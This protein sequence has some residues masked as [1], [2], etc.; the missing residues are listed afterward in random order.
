MAVTHGR[1]LVKEKWVQKVLDANYCV[2]CM[3]TSAIF[4]AVLNKNLVIPVLS[5]INLMDNDLDVLEASYP[6]VSSIEEIKEQLYKI[7]VTNEYN[8][9]A[10]VRD[11]RQ[12]I[13]D[14][15]NPINESTLSSMLPK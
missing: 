10:E 12:S 1:I 9:A 6:S 7:F 15:T 14:G 11:S 3:G 5:E 2:L 8:E 4:N 13:I